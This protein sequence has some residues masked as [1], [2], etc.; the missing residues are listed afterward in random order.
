MPSLT[1]LFHTA[2]VTIYQRESTYI[3]TTK[4]GMPRMLGSTFPIP[5]RTILRRCAHSLPR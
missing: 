3:M 4:E 1:Y 2:D 5:I